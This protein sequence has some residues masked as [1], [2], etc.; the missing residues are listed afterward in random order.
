VA[1]GALIMEG[2]TTDPQCGKTAHH[3]VKIHF[4]YFRL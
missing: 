2:T 1:S 4:L 3:F